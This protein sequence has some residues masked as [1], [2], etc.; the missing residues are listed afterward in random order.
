MN[1]KSIIDKYKD[2]IENFINCLGTLNILSL[3]QKTFSIIVDKIYLFNIAL[4]SVQDTVN[5]CL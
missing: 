1:I 4:K 3:N 2:I 5:V